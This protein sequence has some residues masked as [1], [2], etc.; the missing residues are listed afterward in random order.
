MA[1][2]ER[3][4]MA[5]EPMVQGSKEQVAFELMT[6][7]AR[8]FEAEPYDARDHM[9]RLYEECLRATRS[10]DTQHSVAFGLMKAIALSG[11]DPRRGAKPDRAYVLALYEECLRA[12]H[13]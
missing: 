10:A 3:S 2:G 7:I 5:D 13:G 6:F 4:A 8:N 1:P 11:K 12:V 9:L